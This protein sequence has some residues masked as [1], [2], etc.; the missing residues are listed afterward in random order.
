MTIPSRHE[1]D[2][3]E[4]P[5]VARSYDHLPGEAERH[6]HPTAQLLYA[7]SGVMVVTTEQGRWI[8]PPTRGLWL[9]IGTWHRVRMVGRV[10][11][12]TIY[13]REDALEGLPDECRVVGIPPL[14][15]ELMLAAMHVPL[16]Y[17]V[18]SRDDLLMRLLLAEIR[19]LPALALS[20]P[21]P[22][23]PPLCRVCDDLLAQPDDGRSV[24]AWA[25]SIAIDPRTLQRR[26]L[27]ETGLTFGQWRRQAR[28]LVA[29]ERLAG[30]ERVL[31]VALDLGYASPNAFATMF[32]RELG[33]PPSLF[34]APGE[35]V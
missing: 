11:M 31:D 24:Q 21:R 22:S 18:A 28:L 34:F 16:H 15:R 35:A 13:V 27:R 1:Q 30:G 2:R 12:R 17:A 10:R 9:P 5:V 26:F 6:R 29:L 8:V 4:A 32:K 7:V 14:L 23:T 33:V 19:T 25:A 3:G 20:L